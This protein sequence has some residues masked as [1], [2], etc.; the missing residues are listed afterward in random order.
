ME[1]FFYISLSFKSWSPQSGERNR[2][3]GAKAVECTQEGVFENM[4]AM[5]Y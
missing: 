5:M 1:G 4:K 3:S 2:T